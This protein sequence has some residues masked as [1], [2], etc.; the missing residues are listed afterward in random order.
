M[1]SVATVRG[2][3]AIIYQRDLTACEVSVA[4]N[5]GGGVLDI[6]VRGVRSPRV[7][8]C[9]AAVMLAGRALDRLPDA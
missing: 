5:S 9:E 3:A 7:P 2:N 8:L 1:G 6:D 4:L